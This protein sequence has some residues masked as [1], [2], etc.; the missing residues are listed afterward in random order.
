MKTKFPITEKFKTISPTNVSAD[1]YRYMKPGEEEP[2]LGVPPDNGYLLTSTPQGNRSWV[3]ATPAPSPGVDQQIIF[4][5]NGVLAGTS[6]IYYNP[7]TKR[8]GIGTINTTAKLEIKDT[9]N[10]SSTSFIA[11]KENITDNASSV[12]SLLVDLQVNSVTKFNVTKAGKVTANEFVGPL[13]G[14]ADTATALSAPVFINLNGEVSGSVEFDGTSNVTVTTTPEII[15]F[16]KSLLLENN[17]IDTGI[18]GTDLTTGTYVIQLYAN[19]ASSGGSNIKEYYSGIVSWFSGTTNST[20]DM[21]NDEI[22]LH[23]SGE[24]STPSIYLRTYRSV[25][26]NIIKLQI[27]STV[28]NSSNSTYVFK[29]RKF[30]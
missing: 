18:S 17:W 5:N 21:A 13:T 11:F 29:F 4:N 8:F 24:S 6:D 23:R 15:T 2:N 16:N 27:F 25:L 7:T 19:D 28:S 12:N 9:W 14:N 1:R 3:P 22:P 20:V 26:P 30:I 10:E